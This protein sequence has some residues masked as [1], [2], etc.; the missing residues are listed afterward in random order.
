ME[1][2]FQALGKLDD[3]SALPTIHKYFDDKDAIIASAALMSAADIRTVGSIELVMELMRKLE[4]IDANAKS[5]GGGGY[6]APS[7]PGGGGSD[8]KQALAKAV[9]PTTVKA[10]QKL[11]GEKWTTP[12]EWEIW[13][14]R[15]QATF[16]IEKEEK[17]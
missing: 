4:K 3:E 17:K 5:G 9:L 16:K 12:K 1:A 2:I 15:N 10:M 8:P 14:K 13:W 6:G 7:V 11:S